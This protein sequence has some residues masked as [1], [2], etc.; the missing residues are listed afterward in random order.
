M[1]SRG[2]NVSVSFRPRKVKRAAGKILL[3]GILLAVGLLCAGPFLRMLSTSFKDGENIYELSLIP[4]NPTL[5]N[6]MG[7]IE[8]MDLFRY[9]KNTVI[10]TLACIVIDV[11]FSSMCAYPLAKFDF[12]GKGAVTALLMAMQ[13]MPATAGMVVNYMTIGKMGLMGTYWSAILPSCVTVF[14]VILFRQAYFSIPDELLEAARIDGA[15][16]LKIWYRIMVPQIMPTVSTVII[17]DFVFKWNTFLWPLIVLEPENYP[18]AAALNY[19]K[20]AFTF[21]FGYIAAAT[22]ISIIPILIV[23]IL[24]QKNYINAVGGA[25]KG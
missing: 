8:F 16:E 20:G 18:I 17:F 6:Y 5:A 4:Q 13:I 24:F 23:F 14:S 22:V 9:L 25:V 1:K 7:V 3:Y 19:L 10:I 11:V 12:Y 2:Q 15:S 21:D